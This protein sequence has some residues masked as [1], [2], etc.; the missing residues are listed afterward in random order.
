M[1]LQFINNNNRKKK[2]INE[3]VIK[4]TLKQMRIKIKKLE[5]L[6]SDAELIIIILFSY[7]VEL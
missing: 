3:I 5:E 4:K 1:R 6:K 2:K 7:N